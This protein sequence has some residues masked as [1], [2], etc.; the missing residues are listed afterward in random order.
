M[1]LTSFSSSE[2]LIGHMTIGHSNREPVRQF[3]FSPSREF[4]VGY[5]CWRP[6]AI[7]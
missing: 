7:D 6:F 4:S 1:A 3:R 5:Q 2:N